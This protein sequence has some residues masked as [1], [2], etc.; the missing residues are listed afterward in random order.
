MAFRYI[1]LA[2]LTLLS[3][4]AQYATVTERRPRFRPIR[5]AL[6]AMEQC[7]TRGMDQ[8]RRDPHRA[9]GE[10]LAAA[11]A[12]EQELLR[13]PNDEAARENYNFAVARIFTTMKDA[14]LEPWHPPLRVSGPNGAYLVTHREPKLK[15]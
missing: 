15:V 1:L 13:N 4:C 3:S 11:E 5:Q 6:G 2:S 8:E 10:F 7:I 9:S 12:A 14:K